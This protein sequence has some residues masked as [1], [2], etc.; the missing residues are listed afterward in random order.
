M[1]FIR[2][3]KPEVRLPLRRKPLHPGIILS[4][5]Y[6]RYFKLSIAELARMTGLSR[7][8]LA[9][10]CQ[11]LKPVTVHMAIPLSRLFD[12]TVE[13]WLM[14]QMVWDIWHATRGRNAQNSKSVRPLKIGFKGKA[15]TQWY[16]PLDELT[17]DERQRLVQLNST[18]VELEKKIIIEAKRLVKQ[19]E[20]RLKRPEEN[21]LKDYEIEAMISFVLDKNDP[22][23]RDN[24]DNIIA[25]LDEYCGNLEG[26]T[27]ADGENY[28]D[29]QFTEDRMYHCWLFHSLYGHTKPRLTFRDMLRIGDI[30][31][32][33]VVWYQDFIRLERSMK[34]ISFS[35]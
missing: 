9:M 17:E 27:F 18:L 31:V 33:I 14:G 5:H 29:T 1:P 20:K 15:A 4:Q 30:W 2:S 7:K 23:Y 25:E 35:P 26:E 10:V 12:T 24:D 19:C 21:F 11:G 13:F 34:R 3:N 28:N 8:S 32:D 16:V 22:D 6:M